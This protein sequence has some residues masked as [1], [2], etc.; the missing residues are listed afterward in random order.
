LTRTLC[1][2]QTGGGVSPAGFPPPPEGKSE[3]Q[4]ARRQVE[5]ARTKL[6]EYRREASLSVCNYSMRKRLNS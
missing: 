3:E 1:A 6:R 2:I 5:T 4:D